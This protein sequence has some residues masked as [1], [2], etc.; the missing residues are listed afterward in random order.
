MPVTK[1]EIWVKLNIRKVEKGNL[2]STCVE[3][4]MPLDDPG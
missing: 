2:V 4:E 1:M 3:F